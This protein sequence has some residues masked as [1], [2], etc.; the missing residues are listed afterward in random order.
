MDYLDKL[1]HFAQV[2]GEINIRCEF[3]GEWQ[4]E[5]N[6]HSNSKGIFHLIEEGECWLTLEDQRFHLTQGDIFFLPQERPH[7]MGNL[8]E[9]KENTPSHKSKYGVFEVQKIGHGAADLK[10]FCGAFY[11]QKNALLTTSL[12]DYL[13][14]N[15][16]NTSIQPLVQLF[17]QEAMKQENG[18]QSV[19]DA[20]ANVLFIYIIRHVISFGMMGQGVLYALQDKRLNPV[21][22]RL[23][24]APAQDW[25]IEQLAELASMSRANFIRVFQQQIGMSP[26]RFLTKVRL[27]LAAFLLKQSQKTVL[28]IALEVGY[29]SEAHFSKAFKNTYQVSPSLYRKV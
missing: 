4:V 15:L 17:L 16:R 10:M 8:P 20:L 19:I 29:Q 26:G 7:L 13:H 12:P 9:N 28:A 21:I 2:R 23:L 11:Y 18:N 24:Q 22:L 27:D 1:V 5:H 25:R 3:Q 6:E 14:L